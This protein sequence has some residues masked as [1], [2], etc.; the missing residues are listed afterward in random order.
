MCT[1][2]KGDRFATRTLTKRKDAECIA[3][4]VIVGSQQVVQAGVAGLVQKPFDV[5]AWAS[6]A[7]QEVFSRALAHT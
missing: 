3:A 4:L 6:A 5:R 2:S 7:A 1:S